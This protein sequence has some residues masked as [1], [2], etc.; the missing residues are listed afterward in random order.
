VFEVAQNG[1]DTFVSRARLIANLAEAVEAEHQIDLPYGVA[2]IGCG[3]VL[4]DQQACAELSARVLDL[5]E[6]L[7]RRGDARLR[8]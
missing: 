7:Q 2:G 1:E 6:R 8:P 4:D 3:T 5:A